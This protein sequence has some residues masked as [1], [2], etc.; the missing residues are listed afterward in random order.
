MSNQFAS[1]RTAASRITI[2][3]PCPCN[4]LYS[5]F[6][7]LRIAGHVISVNFFNWA[8][9]LNTMDPKAFLSIVSSWFK[10]F[11]PNVFLI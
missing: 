1:M 2:S 3:T 4:F 11:C 8:L 9:S 7:K 10:I 6:A 5:N